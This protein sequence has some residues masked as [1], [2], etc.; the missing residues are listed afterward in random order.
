MP[1]GSSSAEDL[2]SSDEIKVFK[3]EG[4]DEKRASA[5]LTDLKS[6]LITESKPFDSSPLG[7]PAFGYPPFN[8]PYHNG[9]LG[10]MANKMAS[11]VGVPPS[12]TSL[13]FMMPN[14][15]RL[16]PQPPPAHMGIP[17]VHI[18]TKAVSISA[19]MDF[20]SISNIARN[21][22]YNLSGHPQYPNSVLSDLTQHFKWPNPAMYH[23]LQSA[24]AFHSSYPPPPL[25]SVSSASFPSFVRTP[26]IMPHPSL[27]GHPFTHPG[28]L[29]TSTASSLNEST[30]NP[31]TSSSSTSSS[32]S[33]SKTNR[34]SNGKS[35]NSFNTNKMNGL[36][37]PPILN[38]NDIHQR[39]NNNNSNLNNTNGTNR[40][41][42]RI[43]SSSSNS[44]GVVGNFYKNNNNNS[45]NKKQSNS[46]DQLCNGDI[47]GKLVKSQSPTSQSSLNSP[48]IN[49]F[50]SSSPISS[51][52]KLSSSKSS[53]DQSYRSDNNHFLHS[54]Q[55]QHHH[56]DR[57]MNDNNNN[58][59]TI[60]N[61]DNNLNEFDSGD[62]NNNINSNNSNNNNKTHVKKPL[63]AF[64]IY[65]KEMRAKVIAESTLKESAQINSILGQRVSLLFS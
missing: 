52:S 40:S 62:N 36:L 54:H 27:S 35:T 29:S 58:N 65:M 2:A 3:D 24:A 18:E 26:P 14:M 47:S 45:S 53:N 51:S 17:P 44:S 22:L 63:N 55:S 6:S 5:D 61:N 50:G 1:V 20:D 13:P 19:W 30:S 48:S 8:S 10:Q 39:N 21:S 49:N 4:E 11:M 25:S 7:Y 34:L 15:D 31:S 56:Q 12:G 42:N 9:T 16:Q 28:F 57:L 64:M 38:N 33:S 43:G 46:I 59:N 41:N 32:T 60:N 23:Q 37:S